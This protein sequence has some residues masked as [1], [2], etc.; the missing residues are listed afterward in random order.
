MCEGE[1]ERVSVRLIMIINKKVNEN[2]KKTLAFPA[3]ACYNFECCEYS[4][5]FLWYE[6]V[7]MNIKIFKEA[8][9]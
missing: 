9:K 3:A 2:H 4:S 1:S 7:L 8:H 6:R 5:M